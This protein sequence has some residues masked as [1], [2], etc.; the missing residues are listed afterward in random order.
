MLR[1]GV[2]LIAQGLAGAAC[3][4]SP[5]PAAAP[6]SSSAPRPRATFRNTVG[7]LSDYDVTEAFKA[8]HPRVE[9]CLAEAARRIE[10]VGGTFRV[11]LTIDPE[12]HARDVHLAAST[13][14]DI[15]AERCVLRAV[16]TRRWPKPVGGAGRADHTF[17]VAP[18]E[19]VPTSDPAS[20][21]RH[22]GE[23]QK[24]V[25]PCRPRADGRYRVTVY[26]DASG[27]VM[28]AGVAVPAYETQSDCIAERVRTVRFGP[29]PAVTKATFDLP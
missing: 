27:A 10:W 19:A 20:V 23:V 18:V 21:R 12:G 11:A 2:L 9:G 26:L 16:E 5:P 8:L 15:E 13:L 24:A 7:A 14:G 4:P 3:A 6:P 29:Q 25:S 1:R 22:L 28:A 17:D